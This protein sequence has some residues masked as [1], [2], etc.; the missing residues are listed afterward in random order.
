MYEKIKCHYQK[1]GGDGYGE[2]DTERL[3]SQCRRLFHVLRILRV[4]RPFEIMYQAIDTRIQ[5]PVTAPQAVRA[6]IQP[7]P[8][9]R[10]L[11]IYIP[12]QPYELSVHGG[13]SFHTPH[14]ILLPAG[15][16]GLLVFAS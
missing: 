5:F 7:L 4:S 8:V 12:L 3:P 2:D 6:G 1:N 15:I 13:L 10:I 16:S 9:V 11:V 14:L